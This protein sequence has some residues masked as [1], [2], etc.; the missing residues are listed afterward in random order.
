MPEIYKYILHHGREIL[1]GLGITS[2]LAGV[3][4]G[5]IRGVQFENNLID[6]G[7]NSDH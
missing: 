3:V 6:Q 7:I 4:Y 5:F 2:L 1:I